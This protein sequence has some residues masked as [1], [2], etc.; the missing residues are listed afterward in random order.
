M[1][2]EDI[3]HCFQF[4]NDLILDQKIDAIATVKNDILLNNTDR[5]LPLY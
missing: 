2:R 4:H 1:D 3:L 5:F